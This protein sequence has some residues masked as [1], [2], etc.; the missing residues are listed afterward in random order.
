M[1]K[2]PENSEGFL[3]DGFPRQLDQAEAFEKNI[4]KCKFVLYFECPKETLQ[5]RLLIRG[6]TSG[7]ADDNLE[8]ITKRFDTFINTSLPVIKQY[9][10]MGKCIKVI[11]YAN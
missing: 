1:L 8:T 7:R 2:A 5:E 9:E 4:T 10:E 6:Q 3:I 11:I